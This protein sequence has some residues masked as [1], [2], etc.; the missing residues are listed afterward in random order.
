MAEV[1]AQSILKGPVQVVQ[2]AFDI[3]ALSTVTVDTTITEVDP[4]RTVVI[5]PCVGSWYYQVEVIIRAYLTSPT[6]LRVEVENS[7]NGPSN[8]SNTVTVQVVEY[9]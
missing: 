7:S 2:V 1:S 3:A 4:S 9:N 6:N 8:G 5:M